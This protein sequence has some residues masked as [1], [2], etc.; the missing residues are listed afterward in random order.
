[1]ARPARTDSRH[2]AAGRMPSW[3]EP[4]LA[5]L[6]RERFSDPAWIFERKLDGERCLAFATSSGTR[7]VSRGQRDITGT[8]PEIAWVLAAARRGD[9]A[10]DGQIVTF[11]GGQTRFGRLQQRLGVA[12]PRSHC[13]R[14]CRCTTATRLLR[15]RRRPGLGGDGGHRVR[16]Q[17]AAQPARQADRAGTQPAG[18]RQGTPTGPPGCARCPHDRL[19][20]GARGGPKSTARP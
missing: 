15:P 7:L 14:P 17:D 18:V 20:A 6:T 10:V 11:D 2:T 16:H 12:H 1:M 9:L 3:A 19:V 8:F 5:T 4:Q 13:S